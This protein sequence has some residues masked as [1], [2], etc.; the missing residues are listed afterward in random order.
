MAPNQH[1]CAGVAAM[2][3]DHLPD[4]ADALKTEEA[5]LQKVVD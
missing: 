4:D 1:D 5:G 3:G 2:A